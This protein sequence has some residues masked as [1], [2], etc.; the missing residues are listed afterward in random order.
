MKRIEAIIKGRKFTDKLFGLKKRQI[1]RA[2]ESAKDSA[3]RQKE[4]ATIAY[5]GLFSMMADDNADYQDI[6]VQML[7]HK[8]TVISAEGTI[9]AIEAISADLE[10][11]VE[12]MDDNGKE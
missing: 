9:K 11:E 4:D 3:E 6:I 2:L 5:E 10:S 8:Q 1:R 12:D 7:L